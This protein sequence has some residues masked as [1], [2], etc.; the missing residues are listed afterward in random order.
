MTGT[1]QRQAALL[2]WRL[3][4]DEPHVW[5][6]DRLA[7][8]LGVS[9]IVLMPLHIGL[10]VGRRHQ[11]NDMTKR[12]EFTRPIMCRRA[13][14]DTDQARWQLL[15]ERQHIAALE[16]PADNHHTV[17]IHAVNLKN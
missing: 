9:G 3:G 2:L 4:R 17:S 7:D 12:L 10:H 11:A 8:R 1:V 16:L 5:S 6:G 15:K 14:F 13:G